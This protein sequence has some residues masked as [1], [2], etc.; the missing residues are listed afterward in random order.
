VSKHCRISFPTAPVAPTIPTVYERAV[1]DEE[2]DVIIVVDLIKKEGDRVV[3]VERAVVKT[4]ANA[5]TCNDG[6]G[7]EDRMEKVEEV[8]TTR[9][10]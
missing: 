8:T 4:G 5:E 6:G 7:D 3:V 9:A 1:A 10:E 2:E